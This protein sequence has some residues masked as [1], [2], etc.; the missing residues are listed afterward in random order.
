MSLLADFIEDP[1]EINGRRNT[2]ATTHIDASPREYR[3]PYKKFNIL[4]RHGRLVLRHVDDV[5]SP[6]ARSMGI[7]HAKPYTLRGGPSM[8]L[9]QRPDSQTHVLHLYWDLPAKIEIVMAKAPAKTT[10]EER[11]NGPRPELVR[12][13]TPPLRARVSRVHRSRKESWFEKL[14]NRG[15]SMVERNNEGGRPSKEAS[16]GNGS[17]NVNLPPLLATH[18]GRIAGEGEWA[19]FEIFLDFRLRRKLEC[20]KWTYAYACIPP[21]TTC[22]F[23]QWTAHGL[24]SANSDGKPPYRGKLLQPP[25]RRARTVDLHKWSKQERW[26]L[27]ASQVIKE[28]VSKDQRNPPGTTTKDRKTKTERATKSFEPPPKMFGSKRSRDTS[29]Y[30]HFHE[31]YGHDTNDCR[32][33]KVHIQEAINSGQLS[34]LVKGIKKEKA[35]STDTPRGEGKKDKRS[36]LIF[37]SGRECSTRHRFL[38]KRAVFGRIVEMRVQDS[39]R[40][41]EN[42]GI[43]VSTIHGAIKFHTKK[44]VGTVLSV[45]EAGEETKKARRTL[46]ISK[47]RIPSW[48]FTEEK[49]IVNDKYPKQMV[50]IGKQLPKHFKKE[51]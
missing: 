27:M 32:H 24:P 6:S 3:I 18:I 50:T 10:N 29:K 51:L 7:H 15:E 14:K 2:Q 9:G 23:C 19:T 44:G 37:P 11:K 17:Q 26:P 34:H 20:T 39:G 5:P 8:K 25:T 38:L 48:D 33:L 12:D 40:T 22:K 45:G 4:C 47:E 30:C 41:C 46:T 36:R 43:V 35:K 49:I 28:T 31:D 21:P 16:R 42:I 1:K 13:A